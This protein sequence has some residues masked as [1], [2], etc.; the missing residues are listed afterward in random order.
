MPGKPNYETLEIAGTA[1]LWSWLDSHHGN[2][3][4]ALLVTWKAAH[5]DKYVSRE[6]VLDALVAYGWIDGRRYVVDDAKTAQFIT[7]RLTQHW[8]DSYKKRAA[9]LIEEGRMQPA[10]EA[11]IQA[12]KASGLWDFM[13]DVD[14]LIVPD[15]LGQ[16]LG[17]TLSQWEALAPSYRR[18]VLRWI[19]LAKTA[20]T[21]AKRIAA[22]AKATAQGEKLPQM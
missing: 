8:A 12:G 15:D 14:K 5:A 16:A 4:G 3:P 17:E 6:E 18:N 11:S 20:P 22:T 19:K 2:A 13:A 21:R 10:G 9:R 7:P 1:A